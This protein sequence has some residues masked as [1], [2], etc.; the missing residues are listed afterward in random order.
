MSSLLVRGR[1]VALS[2]VDWRDA[3]S[4]TFR[5]GVQVNHFGGCELHTACVSDRFDEELA[6]LT[7]VRRYLRLVEGSELTISTSVV[8]RVLDE[9]NDSRVGRADEPRC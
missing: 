4:P 2:S 5:I 6:M 9:R 8:D 1:F 7:D 3:S